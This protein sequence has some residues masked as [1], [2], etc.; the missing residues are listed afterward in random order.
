M[1]IIPDNKNEG[2]NKNKKEGSDENHKNINEEYSDRERV[3]HSPKRQHSQPNRKL[4]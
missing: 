3:R 1:R 4:K 2:D